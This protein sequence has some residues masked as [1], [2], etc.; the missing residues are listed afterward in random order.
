M[1]VPNKQDKFAAREKGLHV[2]K[3]CIGHGCGIGHLLE[4]SQCAN[5]F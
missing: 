2:Y 5:P 4:I 1:L 3:I